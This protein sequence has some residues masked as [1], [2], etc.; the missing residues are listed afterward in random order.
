MT[1]QSGAIRYQRRKIV[2]FV[3]FWPFLILNCERTCG[4][5]DVPASMYDRK[6]DARQFDT[7]NDILRSLWR[8][9]FAKAEMRQFGASGTDGLNHLFIPY[10]KPCIYS[11]KK[12]N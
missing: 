1:S 6:T 10:E 12:T 11:Y 7:I 2:K 9:V 5:T 8:N 3:I 4:L